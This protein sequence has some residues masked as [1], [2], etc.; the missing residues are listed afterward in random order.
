MRGGCLDQPVE[1]R[2][3]RVDPA[4]K[5]SIATLWACY[6]DGGPNARIMRPRRK[7]EGLA[8]RVERCVT[9]QT[10]VSAAKAVPSAGDGDNV[11]DPARIPAHASHR[12]T[13]L[14]D[15]KPEHG[16]DMRQADIVQGAISAPC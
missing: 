5:I 11:A 6:H 1:Q 10:A 12:P 16:A 13:I 7:P 9:F 14:H 2:R 4:G 3:R 15:A 8:E